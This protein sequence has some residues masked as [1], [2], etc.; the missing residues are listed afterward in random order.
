MSAPEV[1]LAVLCDHA[2]VG[3]DGKVSVLGVFR[4]ISVMGLPAQHPRM[5]LVAILGLDTGGHAVEVRLRGPDGGAAMA[6]PPRIEVRATAGQDVN[7]IVELN[8]VAFSAYGAHRFDLDV[9]GRT[10]VSLPLSISQMP[11]P[12]Q[13][14][15]N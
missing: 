13:L 9:D 14:R 11:A 8:S 3:Q 5:Y 15:T 12:G 2:I 6:E 7:V 1:R 10:A 4:N